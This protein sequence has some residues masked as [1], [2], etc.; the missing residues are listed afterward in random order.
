MVEFAVVV[1]VFVVV[2]GDEVAAAR[3]TSS[4]ASALSDIPLW[5][6]CSSMGN[7]KVRSMEAGEDARRDA[8][9]SLSF[10]EGESFFLLLSLSSATTFPLF[11]VSMPCRKFPTMTGKSRPCCLASSGCVLLIVSAIC[12]KC[13][14][15]LGCRKKALNPSA[16]V[17]ETAVCTASTAKSRVRK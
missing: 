13:S 1:A 9:F 7:D 16:R 11:G 3:P 8:T 17:A 6:F 10:L 4:P 2:V 14:S 5:L 12:S 15:R